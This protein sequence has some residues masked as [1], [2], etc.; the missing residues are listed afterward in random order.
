MGP[1]RI[2][3]E[4][5]L[6]VPAVEPLETMPTVSLR[7]RRPRRLQTAILRRSVDASVAARPRCAHCRRTPL[8]GEVVHVYLAA[9]GEERLVCD[10]CRSKRR[11][12][13]ADMRLMYSPSHDRSVHVRR[14]A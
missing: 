8:T 9:G 12:P 13:P 11:E 7:R 2:F 10:L 5:R 1:L 4:G 6:R 14:A 3:G